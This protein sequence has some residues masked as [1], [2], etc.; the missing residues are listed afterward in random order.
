MATIVEVYRRIVFMG[1]A[2]KLGLSGAVA[3][4][5]SLA[6]YKNYLPYPIQGRCRSVAF[7]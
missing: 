5:I 2:S 1:K 3:R 4:L 6:R 7:F